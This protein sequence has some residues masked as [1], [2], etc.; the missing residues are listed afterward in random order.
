MYIYGR[1][2]KRFSNI[3]RVRALKMHE[4]YTI[5]SNAKRTEGY[6]MAGSALLIVLL[7]LGWVSF[8]AGS[9]TA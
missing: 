2:Q 6:S 9:L 1:S 4:R 3:T 8:K 7:A 5:F